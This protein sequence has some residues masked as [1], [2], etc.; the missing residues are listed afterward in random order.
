[1][2]NPKVKFTIRPSF[3][4]EID[5][6]PVRGEFVI[7]SD[8][9]GMVKLECT[10]PRNTIII[11]APARPANSYD[12]LPKMLGGNL[13]NGAPITFEAEIVQTTINPMNS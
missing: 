4:L 7:I 12:L 9:E 3:T 1:M 13:K 5:G 8:W 11:N 10:S 2:T 6:K